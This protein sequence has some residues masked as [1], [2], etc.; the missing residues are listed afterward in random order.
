MMAVRAQTNIDKLKVCYIQPVGLFDELLEA[1]RIS[2]NIMDCVEYQL[3]LDR[4]NMSADDEISEM[5]VSVLYEMDGKKHRLG[6]YEF[7]TTGKYK[8]YCFFTF[9]NKAFYTL[10]QVFYGE[11]QNVVGFIEYISDQLGLKFNNITMA[12]VCLDTNRNLIANLRKYIKDYEEYEMFLNGNIVR[13]QDRKLDNYGE[14]YSRSR[15]RICR[16]PTIYLSQKKRSGL[17][18]RIYDNEERQ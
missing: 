14:F 8:G 17:G 13:D 6:E 2:G 7:S 12:E 3:H 16:H 1:F 9:D 15:R 11:K 18:L 4:T 5:E 10:F